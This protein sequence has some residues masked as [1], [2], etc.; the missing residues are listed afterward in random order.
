MIHRRAAMHFLRSDL[1]PQGCGGFTVVELIACIVIIGIISAIAG[2]K[3]FDNKPFSERGYADE[4]AAAIRYA[5]NIAVASGCPTSI[6]LTASDYRLQQHATCTGGGGWSTDVLRNDGGDASG[7][8]PMKG[9]APTGVTLP[10]A[11]RSRL[12]FNA[13]GSLTSGASS[14]TVGTHTIA[15]DAVSGLVTVQ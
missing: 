4:V 13:Q 9:T 11:S 7:L 2:P 15:V 10:S 6:N 3:V 8:V 5:N 12:V 14:L 1:S